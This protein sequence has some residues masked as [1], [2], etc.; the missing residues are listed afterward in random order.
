MKKTIFRISMML[1]MLVVSTTVTLAQQI[2]KEQL[3]E[4]IKNGS[5]D[6]S[7]IKQGT[8]QALVL[9]M[10]NQSDATAQKLSDYMSGPFYDDLAECAYPYYS[11]HI[12]SKDYE[13]LMS[14]YNSAEG[15]LAQQHSADVTSSFMSGLQTYFT[16]D[17]AQKMPQ[18]MQGQQVDPR[19]T[20]CSSSYKA[21]WNSYCES[22]GVNQII[23]AML[24][25]VKG[26]LS[27]QNI[28]ADKKA[29]FDNAMA[30]LSDFLVKDLFAYMCNLSEGKFT[31]ADLDFYAGI[32]TSDAGKHLKESGVDFASNIIQ[33]SQQFEA[34]RNARFKK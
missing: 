23:D 7:N 25:Q 15:K 12:T 26:V 3:K 22:T 10:S 18:I 14:K 31:E 29:E 2:T 32:M 5:V 8:Q 17:L 21:K 9:Q 1:V 16:Q 13:Y 4:L 27:K 28:P 24:G 30:S 6:F 20:T 19:A 34:L 33:F 11:K